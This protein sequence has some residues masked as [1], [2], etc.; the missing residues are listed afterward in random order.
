LARE[1]TVDGRIFMVSG[2]TKLM[3]DCGESLPRV[4]DYQG[5][6]LFLVF[7]TGIP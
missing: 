3:G 2:R 4:R 6:K 5:G 7:T 1:K